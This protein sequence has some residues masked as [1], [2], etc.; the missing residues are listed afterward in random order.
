MNFDLK[1]DEV[2]E[3]SVDQLEMELWIK[4]AASVCSANDCKKSEVAVTWANN[5]T[6][7]FKKR[8]G[9]NKI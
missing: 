2:Q 1:K 6:S 8:Y 5:I 7:A 3:K 9:N 4:I